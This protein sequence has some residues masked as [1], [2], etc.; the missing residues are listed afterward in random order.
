ME[1]YI[2]KSAVLTEIENLLYKV[3]KDKY[4]DKYDYAYRD[5]NNG[6][7]YALKGKLDTLEVK[8]V[9]FTK[10]LQTFSMDLATK[11][12]DGNWDKDIAVT[13]KH[14]FEFGLKART[15]KEL[16]EEVYSHLDSIKDTA[17]RMTS[18]NFMHNRA[19]IKFSVNTI[20][21]VL[22]LMGLKAQKEK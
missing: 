12:N 4:H 16:V 14:F 7:L 20:A 9:N 21:K 1:Q 5:G 10:E 13:A 2:S 18:C 8:E 19:A 6:A 3:D 11:V 17:D 22:E 15:D